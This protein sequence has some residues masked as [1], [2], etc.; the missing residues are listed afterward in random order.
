MART[1]HPNDVA[2]IEL[3]LDAAAAALE[4]FTPGAIASRMKAGDDPVTAA[5][6]A[7]NQALLNVLPAS[8]EGW[9]SEE[10]RDDPERLRCS[11]VW[12]VD[13]VD[14]TREFIEGIPEWCVSV[15]LVVDGQPVA[16]GIL[17]PAGGH[18]MVGSIDDGVRCNGGPATT[19]AHD[20]LEGALVLASRSEV[21]RGEWTRFF[22]TSISVRNMG[23]VAYKLGLVAS[24]LADATW[25]LVPKHEWDVAAGAALVRSAGGAV[26][27]PDG[28]EIRFNAAAPKLPGFVATNGALEQ[29]VRS[30]LKEFREEDVTSNA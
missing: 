28:E 3:A 25:T 4:P 19:S 5:D 27:L 13:P 10:T 29:P 14:G 16:G 2:R 6:V 30:F 18:R 22:S 24:G 17:S 21:K 11:R 15:G 7:V 9:L 1:T 23:S 8:G 12:V 20:M 26:F